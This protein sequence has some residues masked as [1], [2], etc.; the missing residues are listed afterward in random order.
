MK[1]GFLGCGN[2]GGAVAKAL[3]LS[4]K[5][6][7]L[8]SKSV[9]SAA[10]LADKLGCRWTAKNEDVAL[11]CDIIL[12]AVKPQ[13]M[14]SVL[15]PLRSILQERKPLL[16]SMAAGLTISQLEEM[17]GGNI[18]VIRIMPNTPVSIGQGMT[19]Y[20]HNHLVSESTMLALL[21]DL[22]HAGRFDGISESLM[23]AACV[24][25]GC[26]PAYAYMFIEAMADGAVA[27]GLPR[28][29]ALEYA[30][31]AVSGAAQ[32]LLESG[33][34]PGVL[35][36]A[37]CSPGGSTIAGVR[38]LEENGFRGAVMDAISAAF[39]RSIELGK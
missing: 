10:N 37:V 14:A 35:K 23:D 36:D 24:A 6:I 33:A 5:D 26:A 30:A 27:C 18:P 11:Y 17:A 39:Q 34:H 2:M 15:T 20:C 28:A 31:A 4:T 19:A 8:T 9:D 12:L 1:Y 29:K 38:A 3:S 32:L 21:S 22:S 13:M 7:L 25:A 16:V